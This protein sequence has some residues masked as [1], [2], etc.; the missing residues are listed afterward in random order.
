MNLSPPPTIMMTHEEFL[1]LWTASHKGPPPY[2]VGGVTIVRYEKGVNGPDQ[3][4]LE[5]EYFSRE[6]EMY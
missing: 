6:I 1:V 5:G 4:V 3:V 2:L